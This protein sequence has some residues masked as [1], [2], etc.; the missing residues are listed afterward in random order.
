MPRTPGLLV[1]ML[2]EHRSLNGCRMILAANQAAAVLETSWK[3]QVHEYRS[4]DNLPGLGQRLS[5]GVPIRLSI[6]RAFPVRKCPK[7][8]KPLVKLK[9]FQIFHFQYNLVF[10]LFFYIWSFVTLVGWWIRY[11]TVFPFKRVCIAVHNHST[12]IQFRRSFVTFVTISVSLLVS[13]LPLFS[14]K[15]LLIRQ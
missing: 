2:G 12:H 1:H 13:F 6:C 8:R 10:I 5:T 11:N 3:A 7:H 15:K 14:K 4:Y 9:I